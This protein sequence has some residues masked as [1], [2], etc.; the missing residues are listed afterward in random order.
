MNGSRNETL[1]FGEYS[2]YSDHM[3]YHQ[4]YGGFDWFADFFYMNGAGSGKAK[5]ASVGGT[6]IHA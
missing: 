5:K 2:G 4:G 6:A 1:N 3:S